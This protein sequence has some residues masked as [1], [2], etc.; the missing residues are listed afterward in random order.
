M[1]RSHLNREG[2]GEEAIGYYEK[3]LD[4]SEPG[5]RGP[6]GSP[7]DGVRPPSDFV[8]FAAANIVEA[9][10]TYLRWRIRPALN[11]SWNDTTFTSNSLGYRTPE[12]DLEKP[13]NVYR[14][15]VFGS[16]NTMGHGVDDDAAYPRLLEGW[17][18]ERY[19]P[20]T[21]IEVVNLAVAGDS[22]SKRLQRLREEGGRFQADW[23][24]CDAS[25]LDHL[26]EEG[27]LEAVVRSDPPIE[28]PFEFVR[29]AL[30]RAEV[31]KADP[32]EDFRRELR[33]SRRTARR[34]LRGL[35]GRGGEAR[36]SPD[37]GDPPPRRPETPEPQDR[38]ADP[39]AGRAERD[40]RPRSLQGVRPPRAGS[41][42]RLGAGQAPQRDRAPGAL[43]GAPLRALSRRG[44]LPGLP[45]PE[46]PALQ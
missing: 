32:P 40:R 34:G 16:S 21:R 43:R 30:R 3:I 26:L 46:A 22:P 37:H 28:I 33:E 18:N 25:P 17:L 15:L 11:V 35:E 38:G 24:L 7:E 45:L 42:P 1:G 39:V 23:I 6:G 20:G 27:H 8:P 19:G 5:D 36:D 10:P 41:V 9:T 4:A 14:I 13:L 2:P 44:S 29:Q 31:S 12:I